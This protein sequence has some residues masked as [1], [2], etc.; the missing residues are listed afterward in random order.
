MNFLA[1]LTQSLPL[2]QMG[3]SYSIGQLVLAAILVIGVI[4]ILVVFMRARGIAIPPE[5]IT[6]GWIVLAVIIA[7][8][9]VKL[10]LSQF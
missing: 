5:F 6:Y 7:A 10:I 1:Q 4:S 8:V 3:S 9:A 2:A